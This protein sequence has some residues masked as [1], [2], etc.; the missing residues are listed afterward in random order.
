MPSTFGYAFCLFHD[1]LGAIESYV[2]LIQH[3]MNFRNVH[4]GGIL[5]ESQGDGVVDVGLAEVE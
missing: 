2:N 1:R 3:A 5:E 4:A